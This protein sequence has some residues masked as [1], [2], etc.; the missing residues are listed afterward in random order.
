MGEAQGTCSSPG[1]TEGEAKRKAACLM[2]PGVGPAGAAGGGG[3]EYSLVL[4]VFKLKT[5]V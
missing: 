3:E 2:K 4:I 1:G 5:S